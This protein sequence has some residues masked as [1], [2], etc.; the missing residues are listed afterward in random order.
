MTVNRLRLLIYAG[1]GV[2]VA[3]LHPD[4]SLLKSP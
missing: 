3:G 1:W 2:S 4:R